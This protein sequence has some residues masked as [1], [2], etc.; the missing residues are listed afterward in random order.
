MIQFKYLATKRTL[1]TY[2][3]IENVIDFSPSQEKSMRCTPTRLLVISLCLTF[4]FNFLFR[5]A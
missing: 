3:N 2:T 4:H 1:E 5:E